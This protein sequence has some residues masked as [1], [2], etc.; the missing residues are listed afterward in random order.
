M[1]KIFLSACFLLAFLSGEA[2][3]KSG[4]IC[5]LG[6]TYDIS[7]SKNWGTGKPVVTGIAPYS[8]AERAG[9]KQGDIIEKIDGFE[10][11]A[12]TAGEITGL[13]N[14]STKNDI[15]LTISNITNPTRQVIVRKECKKRNAIT[16]DQLAS[17]FCMY[18]LETTAER[19]FTCPFKIT[20]VKDTVQFS[21][22]KTFAFSPIDE[23]NRKLE[24]VI[25][26]TIENE[27]VQK[28][29]E[30]NEEHP[31]ILV[32]TFYF[33][34][35]NPNY[36]GQNQ[37]IVQKEK[38]FR[39]NFAHNKMEEFPFLS[40]SASESEAAYLL[41]YGFRLID[42]RDVPGRVLWECEA[43]EMLE[44]PF[45]LEEYARIH[46]PLMCMQYPYV[47]F[48]RN[49]PYTVNQKVYNYTGISYNIDK[50]GQIANVDKNSPAYEAGI[51]AGDWVESIDGLSMDYTAEEFSAAYKQ[52]ITN[53]MKYRDPKTI[54]TDANGFT[55]CMHW[56]TFQYP[57]VS[58]AVQDKNN[59]SA[60]S[61]LYN[62]APYINPTGNNAC[63]FKVLRGKN[64]SEYIIRPTIR[65]EVTIE[66]K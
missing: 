59:R 64:E 11:D 12:L 9:I 26:Q 35:K 62:F 14:P 31:D 39:Y 46:T 19:R 21:R 65:T 2:Q 28:G 33:F 66:V 3:N 38:T 15:V 54:F 49:I 56:D 58:E 23:S 42:Q 50:M 44:E 29:L 36:M 55:R 48:T 37:V 41:Q 6:I 16:E 7:K 30:Y 53:T 47:K 52:F 63:T 61:Y 27:L 1:K 57:Y 40:P 20:T 34:D 4:F 8:S 60:F 5:R 10:V 24:T 13:M 43:N 22:F 18:S 51:R 32:Q 45:H 25:N 17:A